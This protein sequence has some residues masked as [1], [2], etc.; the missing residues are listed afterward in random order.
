MKI[1]RIKSTQSHLLFVIYNDINRYKCLQICIKQV[2][3]FTFL[4]TDIILHLLVS[5][6]CIYVYIYIYI[7]IYTH[8][9]IYMHK[10]INYVIKFSL[11]YY[12]LSLS[13]IKNL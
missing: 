11:S 10:L 7:Y 12:F 8:T 4:M 6:I 9:H 2:C 5:L 3:I 1:N 13:L